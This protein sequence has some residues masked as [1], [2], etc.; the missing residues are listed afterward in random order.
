MALEPRDLLGSVIVAR[1]AGFRGS[2]AWYLHLPLQTGQTSWSVAT[3]VLVTLSD[4]AHNTFQNGLKILR[5]SLV[6][7]RMAYMSDIKTDRSRDQSSSA[8]DGCLHRFTGG[9]DH[10]TL[11]RS[12]G[13]DCRVLAEATN[14]LIACEE[15]L[16]ED[17]GKANVQERLLGIRNARVRCN[18]IAVSLR[19]NF[20]A[21][22]PGM[23]GSCDALRQYSDLVA[24]DEF[25]LALPAPRPVKASSPRSD[26]RLNCPIPETSNN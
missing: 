6:P 1:I 25:E 4:L 26:L 23:E 11:L 10:A 20:R 17:L 16:N 15:T 22:I 5:F 12:S 18:L 14:N 21:A 19:A 3:A 8:L 2:H 13:I 24:T 7:F 9:C